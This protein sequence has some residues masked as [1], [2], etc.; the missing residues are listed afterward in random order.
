MDVIRI[1][2]PDGHDLLHFGNGEPG[3]SRHGLVEVVCSLSEDEVA[4]F[5]CLPR[6]D[7]SEIT[8]HVHAHAHAHARMH[9]HAH[10]R[11]TRRANI[12]S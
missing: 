2:L 8:L 7:K 12:S 10:S 1:Q 11:C 3:S 4:G 5:V 6:F 9:V